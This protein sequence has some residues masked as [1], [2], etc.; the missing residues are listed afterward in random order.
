MATSMVSVA[1]DTWTLIS[2]TSVSF[3]VQDKNK[4]VSVLEA[5]SLPTDRLIGKEVYG[6]EYYDFVKNDGNLYMYSS[7]SGATVALDPLVG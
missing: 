6:G 7:G 4:L 1:K 2:T 5:A 3:Q